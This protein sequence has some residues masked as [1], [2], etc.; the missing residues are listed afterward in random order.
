M[1][2]AD[3]RR[4][5]NEIRYQVCNLLQK[6]GEIISDLRD[7]ILDKRI[8]T[9]ILHLKSEISKGDAFEALDAILQ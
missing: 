4:E 6:I 9:G 1:I 7:K 2:L 3:Q 8:G 5:V